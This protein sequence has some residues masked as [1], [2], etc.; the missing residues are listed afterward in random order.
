MQKRLLAHVKKEPGLDQ[1]KFEACLLE[2]RTFT[3]IEKDLAF[4][5]E[6][7]VQGTPTMFVN[8]HRV[9]RV[10]SAEQ[11]RTLIRQY[12]APEQRASAR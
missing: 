12:S 2:Q 6:I 7:G 11:I 4:G 8:A 1:P 5:R 9:E 3:S 10:G